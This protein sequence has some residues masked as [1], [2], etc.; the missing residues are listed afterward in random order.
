MFGLTKE[1]VGDLVLVNKIPSEESGATSNEHEH[2]GDDS[3]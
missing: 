2:Y 3:Y 1:S